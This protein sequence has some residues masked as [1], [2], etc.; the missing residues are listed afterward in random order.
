MITGVLFAETQ[1]G[2]GIGVFEFERIKTLIGKYKPTS[3][4]AVRKSARNGLLKKDRY[5]KST[6]SFR[7]RS[8]FRQ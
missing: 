2:K 8:I 4:S 6:S 7:K 5:T 1:L 3:S